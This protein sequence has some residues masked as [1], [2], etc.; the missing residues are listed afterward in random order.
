MY[1]KLSIQPASGLISEQGLIMLVEQKTSIAEAIPNLETFML[2]LPQVSCPVV[3]HF[4]PG[5]AIREVSIPA[6]TF[7]VGHYQNFEH[8]NIMLKGC[9]H[10][11]ND[12]ASITELKAP[13]I[14]TGKPGRKI[15]YISE[16]MVWLNVF[17]TN[18]TDVEKLE[19]TFMTKSEGWQANAAFKADL[20]VLKKEIDKKDYFKL[21]KE[22][23]FTPEQAK[24]QSH[25]TSDI[26]DLPKGSYKIKVS[27]SDIEGRGLFATADIVEGEII[28][29]A[30]IKGLRTIAGR[31]ANHSISPNAQMMHAG[32]LDINLVAIK[33]IEGCKGGDN[34][35]EITVSYR[36]S[37]RLTLQLGKG[38]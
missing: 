27:E 26:V 6:G 13:L 21:L 29:P 18:E 25:N 9:V 7:A 20:A 14:F 24:E 32:G 2:Q 22:F 33:P 23:G 30:R 34:G 35:E 38:E 1:V 19:A 16:D 15:G 8:L 17:S 36:D 3:H 10:V 28:A 5:I 11:L 12:D 4:G 31:F 37:L